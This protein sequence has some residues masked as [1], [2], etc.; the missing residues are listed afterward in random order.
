MSRAGPFLV[1][2]IGLAIGLTLLELSMID[3]MYFTVIS[4]TTIGYGDLNFQGESDAVRWKQYVGIFFLPLAVTA[5]ADSVSELARISVRKRIRQ[6]D[7]AAQVR[8][9]R[10][11]TPTPAGSRRR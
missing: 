8:R 2:L 3:A 6:T 10:R 4:M 1:F 5:L 7:Y 11:P 9:A